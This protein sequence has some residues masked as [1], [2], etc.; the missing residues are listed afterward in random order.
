MARLGWGANAQL[1]EAA[2]LA[3]RAARCVRRQGQVLK[4]GGLQFSLLPKLFERTVLPFG[5]AQTAAS[6]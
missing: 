3:L 4:V 2:G 1:D 5:E 6:S